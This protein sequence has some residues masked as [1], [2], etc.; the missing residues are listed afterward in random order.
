MMCSLSEM[1]VFFQIST[2]PTSLDELRE[3]ITD[4]ASLHHR[5]DLTT[6]ILTC[7][8]IYISHSER[9]RKQWAQ[10]RIVFL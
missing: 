8:D 10:V 5:E 9:H 7:R 4:C 6:A 2:K 3:K 1:Q